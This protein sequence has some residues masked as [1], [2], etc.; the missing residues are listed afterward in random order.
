M[1]G[2]LGPEARRRFEVAAQKARDAFELWLENVIELDVL[3][4]DASFYPDGLEVATVALFDRVGASGLLYV[5]QAR[6]SADESGRA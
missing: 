4:E 5:L 1:P 3:P 2:T 6:D